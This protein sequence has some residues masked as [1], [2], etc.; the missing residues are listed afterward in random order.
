MVGA[1]P[2]KNETRGRKRLL[3]G[4]VGAPLPARAS[5]KAA[6]SKVCKSVGGESFRAVPR[7]VKFP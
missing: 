7:L 4:K 5:V 6:V 3:S 2:A 1:G